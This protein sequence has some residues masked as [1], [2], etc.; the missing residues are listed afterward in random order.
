MDHWSVNKWFCHTKI[1]LRPTWTISNAALRHKVGGTVAE[2]LLCRTWCR[3]KW[4]RHLR[5]AH[6]ELHVWEY[7]GI[8]YTGSD[9]AAEKTA[10]IWWSG[11]SSFISVTKKHS[12]RCGTAAEGRNKTT[13]GET[14]RDKKQLYTLHVDLLTSQ[15]AEMYP[16]PHWLLFN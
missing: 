7:T 3:S 8:I 12:N 15:S 5:K 16:S 11:L 6:K 10:F 2:H 9:G 4:W 13:T 1:P 14:K